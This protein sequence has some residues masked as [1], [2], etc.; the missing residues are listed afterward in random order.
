MNQK[1]DHLIPYNSSFTFTI[2]PEQSSMRLD[3]FIVQQF[4]LYSRSF[5]NQLIHKG[6]IVINNKVQLK[7]GIKLKNSDSVTISFPAGRSIADQTLTCL[8]NETTIIYQHDHFL[9]LNKPA[10][11]LVH[12]PS[13]YN[14]EVTLVDWL[15]QQDKEIQSVG[16]IDRPGIVHRLDKDT[17]GI[18][19]IPRTNY[20]HNH[21]GEL[22][23]DRSI[24]KTYYAVVEGHPDREGIIDAGIG[25]DPFVK[26]KM[27]CF[28]SDILQKTVGKIRNAHSAYKVITYFKDHSLL[29]VK[30]VT[31]RTHQIRVHLA[32][33]GHPI[34]GDT[35]YGKA[36]S[37]IARQ[38]LHAQTISFIFDEQPYEISAPLP[39]D[40]TDLC[41]QLLPYPID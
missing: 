12:S 41:A 33:I 17:S 9:V 15:L 10:G 32:H 14:T 22:F 11:L 13:Q 40:M 5:F 16:A 36:S 3:T 34:V 2:Q 31:G 4:P 8:S 23:R 19:I 39:P 35:V 30:P 28:T 6:Y 38:A 25:R 37:L 18:I 20:A 7:S 27:A 24:H 29:E 1:I 21:F 26:I